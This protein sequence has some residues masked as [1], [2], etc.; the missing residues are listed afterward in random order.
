MKKDI[1]VNDVYIDYLQKTQRTQIFFGGSSSGKSFFL[2]QRTIKDNLEGVNYLVVRNVGATLRN[3]TFN[4]LKKAIHAMGVAHLYKIN[5]GGMSITCKAN[6][7]QILFSGLDNVEKL[8]SITPSN[9]VLERIW[10]E[11][12]TEIK[13]EAYMQLK[14]RLRGRTEHSKSITL[15]F[16]PILKDHW[17][18]KEFFANWDDTKR[19]YEDYDV[20]ILKTTYKDNNYLTEDDIYSLEN[21]GDP[22]FRDVYTYGNWGVLGNVVYRNWR[23]ADLSEEKKHFDNIYNGLDFGYTNPNA[24]VRI[25]VD[26]ER[27]KIYVLDELYEKGQSY[28]DLAE[29]VKKVVGN[30]YVMCDCEDGRAIFTLNTLGVKAIPVKKGM[31]SVLFGI[32][33]LQGFEII[34]DISCQNFKNEIQAYHWDEDKNGNVLQRPVKKHDHLLDALRYATESLQTVTKANVGLGRL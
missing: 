19:R 27:K 28:E 15:S 25:H 10:I 2:A 31:N 3:S 32:K 23:M 34:I 22:Y 33:W 17:I 7:K 1:Y 21:E 26:L 29:S 11:E 30:E 13:R 24:F 18:Y 4:E 16:N 20:S 5:E 12:A 9:G 8:K 6:G 14:K